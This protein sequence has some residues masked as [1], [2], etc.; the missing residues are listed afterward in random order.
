ML[1]EIEITS[2]VHR[3]KPFVAEA[4][5]RDLREPRPGSACQ[6]AR[7]A[8]GA[9]GALGNVAQLQIARGGVS[10]LGFVEHTFHRDVRHYEADGSWRSVRGSV[11]VGLFEDHDASSATSR[12]KGTR[13]S[14]GRSNSRAYRCPLK[15]A[16]A[17]VP[18]ARQSPIQ[19]IDLILA[20]CTSAANASSS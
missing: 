1:E 14:F 9:L 18:G 13:S 5:C 17:I 16:A 6:E 7:D 11:W 10:V 20:S 3:C 8:F 15:T 19:F 4:T 2:A 12:M